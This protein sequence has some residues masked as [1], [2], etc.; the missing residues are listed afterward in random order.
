MG[1]RGEYSDFVG[2]AMAAPTC[3]L[4]PVITDKLFRVVLNNAAARKKND[5]AVIFVHGFRG[6]AQDTWKLKESEESFPF[7]LASDPELPDHD[8]YIF[9][10]VTKSLDPPAIDNIVAQLKFVITDKL[11]EK[12]I[13]FIAHSMGG[14]VAMRCILHFLEQGET[15]SFCGLLLYGTPMT[16]VEWVKY[17]QLVL[18]LATFKVPVLGLISR[19]LKTNKQVSALTEGS[20]FVEKLNGN[21]VLRVLNGGHPKIVAAQRAWFPVRVVSGNDDWVVKQSSARGF[22]S[23]IDWIDVDTDHIRL[24]KPKD[25]LELTYQIAVNFLKD[26]RRWINPK[27]LQKLRSQIDQIWGLHQ[28]RT[29]ADWRFEVSFE[30]QQLPA[31]SNPFGIP[32]FRPFSVTE[33]SYRRKIDKGVLKFGFAIGPIAA[34]ALWTDDFAFLHSIRFG[35]LPPADGQILQD[36]LR[37]VLNTHSTAWSTLFETAAINIR[38]PEGT[39]WQPLVP[40]DIEFPNDGLVRTFLIPQEAADLIGEEAFVNVSFRGLLPS[41][42]NDYEVQFPWLCDGFIVRATVKGGPSYIATS[43]GMRGSAILQSK[44]EQQGKVEYSSED[45]IFPG[46]YLHVEWGF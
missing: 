19:V 29:I 23:E 33:C 12:R 22:Y 3:T 28:Q 30:N 10:Y 44:K 8:F 31:T 11:Q 39:A 18:Q 17:A 42:I 9:Q 14:L 41:A 34:G 4:E 36:Q 25:R 6:D 37:T 43:Q 15:Q 13:M 32:N 45:L 24:V 21:W 5:K 46:S 27:A 1:D 26:C 7:M 38:H 2:T 40:S 16:G 35:A 20:E